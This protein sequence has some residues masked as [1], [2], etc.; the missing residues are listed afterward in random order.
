MEF[1]DTKGVSGV[2]IQVGIFDCLLQVCR[3]QEP[4]FFSPPLF[5]SPHLGLL[6]V[7]LFFSLEHY[8]VSKILT[9][10]KF[11]KAPCLSITQLRTPQIW[12]KK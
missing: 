10:V 3:I 4:G 9:S 12:T 11:K 5:L 1:F 2:E 7:F 6:F 8:F